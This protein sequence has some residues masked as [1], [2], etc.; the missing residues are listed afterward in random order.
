[1]GERPSEAIL[2]IHRPHPPK[3]TWIIP[4]RDPQFPAGL[5]SG[6]SRTRTGLRPPPPQS[7]VSTISPH[8]LLVWDCK[9]TLILFNCKFFFENKSKQ[10]KTNHKQ[11]SETKQNETKQNKTKRNKTER[12]KAKRNRTDIIWADNQWYSRT[13][14]IGIHGYCAGSIRHAR[15][16]FHSLT[17][18]QYTDCEMPRMEPRTRRR[19]SV[20][21]SHITLA[22]MPRVGS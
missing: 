2:Y 19:P 11:I 18:S 17:L 9:D 7:G 14:S 21:N 12:N 3:S 5:F 20:P 6:E 10:I 8:P 22:L 13:W 16:L 4:K 1:M 15:R